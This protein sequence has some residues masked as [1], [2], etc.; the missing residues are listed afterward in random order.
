M[1]GNTSPPYEC[2]TCIGQMSQTWPLLEFNENE[3][4]LIF[5]VKQFVAY[6]TGLDLIEKKVIKSIAMGNL[7]FF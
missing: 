6:T 4:W 2:S 7:I 5:Y 1:K 3:F